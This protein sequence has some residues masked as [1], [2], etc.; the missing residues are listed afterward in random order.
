MSTKP[1]IPTLVICYDRPAHLACVL[2]QLGNFLAQDTPITIWQ[3]G[4]S[5]D[6]NT[7]NHFATREVARVFAKARPL[8]TVHSNVENLGCKIS[9]SRAISTFFE[10]YKFGVVLEDDI[11]PSASFYHFISNYKNW[12]RSSSQAAVIGGHSLALHSKHYINM[13]GSVWGWATWSDVWEHYTESLDYDTVASHIDRHYPRSEAA[14]ELKALHA[15][16]SSVETYDTWD[17]HWLGTR[18]VNSLYTLMPKRPLCLNIGFD[19]MGT[20]Y[21]K[22]SVPFYIQRAF[23]LMCDNNLFSTIEPSLDLEFSS[24]LI[25][26]DPCSTESLLYFKS[27]TSKRLKAYNLLTTAFG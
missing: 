2:D 18:I 22:R 11:F 25:E 13:H 17:Y 3:D 19:G 26:V 24:D 12:A 6:T 21:K 1:M 9:V 14:H 4:L 16:Y 20:H 8:V 5:P 7:A 23:K 15:F 27:K 10:S